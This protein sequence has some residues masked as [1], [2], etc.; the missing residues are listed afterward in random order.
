MAAV[1]VLPGALET[2]EE[3]DRGGPA[4]REPRVRR[5]HQLGQ[6]LVDDLDHLLARLEPLQHLLAERPLAHGSD[7]LLDDLEV[8]VRLEQGEADLPRRAG[9]RLLVEA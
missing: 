9:D 2:A 5:S 1:V 7:E 3:D 6:L 4:E 8:D